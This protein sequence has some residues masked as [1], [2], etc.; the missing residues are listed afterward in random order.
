VLLGLG[1]ILGSLATAAAQPPRER[2][3]EAPARVDP[4][5]EAWVKVLA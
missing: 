5:V 1:V 2:G 4:A 3:G